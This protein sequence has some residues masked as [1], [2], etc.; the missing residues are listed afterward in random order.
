TDVQEA[1]AGFDQ[2]VAAE[3]AAERAL[4]TAQEFLR[5]IIGEPAPDL[6]G[7]AED[8]PLVAPVP[9]DPEAWVEA[10][11]Q[12]NLALVS[13]RIAADIAQDNIS[14]RRA[15]RLPTLR[16]SSSLSESSSDTVRINSFADGSI[17]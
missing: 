12:Q 16:F 11:M 17:A 6:A 13:S 10:A 14:I 5:E 9:A 3:I 15:S 1:Q 4:A 2:A 7:P 8:L